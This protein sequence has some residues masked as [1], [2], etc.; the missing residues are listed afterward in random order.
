M[1]PRKSTKPKTPK[2]T[3]AERVLNAYHALKKER[4]VGNIHLAGIR[5]QVKR[6]AEE[7]GEQLGPNWSHWVS[8]AVDKL[9][10]DGI[11][12]M[13]NQRVFL[14]PEGKSTIATA[15]RS[16]RHVGDPEER[17][18]KQVASIAASK[19]RYSVSVAPG[20]AYY[21]EA[22]TS[23]SAA[24]A[25]KRPR[26]HTAH[27]SQAPLQSTRARNARATAVN[28]TDANSATPVRRGPGRPSRKSTVRIAA[29]LAQS[30]RDAS[31]LTDISDLDAEYAENNA[32]L[33]EALRRRDDV[34]SGLQRRLEEAVS[35][36]PVATAAPRPRDDDDDDDGDGDGNVATVAGQTRAY[37]PPTTT[38]TE[39][40]FSSPTIQ[41]RPGRPQARN[42]VSKGLTRTLSGSVIPDISKQPTPAPSEGEHHTDEVEQVNNA[43][44]SP[45]SSPITHIQELQDDI[46]VARDL[47]NDRVDHAETELEKAKAAFSDRIQALEDEVHSRDTRIEELNRELENVR[48]KAAHATSELS[49]HAS[50]ISDME[51]TLQSLQK[52]NE[53][54]REQLRVH[55]ESGA[56][57]GEQLNQKEAQLQQVYRELE[58]S[59][60]KAEALETRCDSNATT[61]AELEASVSDGRQQLLAA[62]ERCA[63][64]ESTS[65]GKD[66]QLDLLQSQLVSLSNEL[67][68]LRSQ[69][70][71][72]QEAL[73]KATAD[74]GEETERRIRR[75]DELATK[76]RELI[77]VRQDLDTSS[78]EVER[79]GLEVE[80]QKDTVRDLELQLATATDSLQA[81]EVSRV[82]EVTRHEEEERVL[83]DA[84][85][86][87][88]RTIGELRFDVEESQRK[89][90][91]TELEREELRA[92]GV[93]LQ[94]DL[95]TARMELEGEKQ[96]GVALELDLGNQLAKTQEAQD[97]LARAMKGNEALQEENKAL[98]ALVAKF[99]G[100][101][102]ELDTQ[103]KAIPQA[104]V[105]VG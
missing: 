78:S 57:L 94:A 74:L 64:L 105:S 69:A 79:L 92:Q 86:Q 68:S 95:L 30:D 75:D 8:K 55:R 99:H 25:P 103:A 33:R 9:T 42:L 3:Y 80:Q 10:E 20:A 41:D 51:Q 83:K 15:K 93:G 50:K 7:K 89:L 76:E 87:L 27:Y 61:I 66:Q 5:A 45:E 97:Q 71:D 47:L 38:V 1:A 36:R 90:T 96:R 4:R 18:F 82:A 91:V 101:A 59:S 100:L 73:A 104:P 54:L 62:Q 13:G 65:R 60:S 46:E 44:P 72:R 19:R 40:Q 102:M 23:I 17:V 53:F 48:E 28:T 63:E 56:S 39:H 58:E 32:Q 77:Q 14:T 70:L 81:L 43:L 84:I 11:L 98:R 6:T 24:R 67:D 22:A 37:R 52:E 29:P 34:I 85:S 26:R 21:D 31:P 35:S 12:G 49:S 2:V 88:E 16:V